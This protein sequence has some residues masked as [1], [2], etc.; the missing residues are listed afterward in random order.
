[1]TKDIYFKGS[2]NHRFLTMSLPPVRIGPP[3]A[4]RPQPIPKPPNTH[5]IN[6]VDHLIYELVEKTNII[7]PKGFGMSLGLTY[8]AVDRIAVDNPQSISEQ[9]TKIAVKWFQDGIEHTWE[10]VVEALCQHELVYDSEQLAKRRGV[11]S[12]H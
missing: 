3:P 12:K 2:R 5:P 11:V 7:N 6:K 8:N 9:L 1:M 10:E 4:P